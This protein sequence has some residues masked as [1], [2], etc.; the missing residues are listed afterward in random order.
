M[1]DVIPENDWLP[2]K[3]LQKLTFPRAD[4]FFTLASFH[5]EYLAKTF[6]IKNVST[7]W[8]HVD[9]RFW[10]PS[11][12]APKGPILAIGED[13][14]RDFDT[15]IE[16]VQDLDIDLVIK[17]RRNLAQ[18]S[19]RARIT[20]ITDKM[21]FLDLRDLYAKASMVV[22]PLYQTLNASGVGSVVEAAAMAKPIVISDNVPIRDYI[23]PG[24]TALVV[25][26]NDPGAMREAILEIRSDPKKGKAL[27]TAARTLAESKFSKPVFAE[28]MASEIRKLVNTQM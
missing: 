22:V 27:G 7:V 1:W 3:I 15:L 8:K 9:T 21:S 19:G 12:D 5:G 4:H 16:A 23:I 13:H 20:Q 2:R 24:E 28:R 17:T 10:H 6:G 25:P 11:H 18:K 26:P 14:G